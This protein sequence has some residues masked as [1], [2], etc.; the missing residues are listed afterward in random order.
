MV[1]DSFMKTNNPSAP[2]VSADLIDELEKQSASL[3]LRARMDKTVDDAALQKVLTLIPSIQAQFGE[4][5]LVP[6]KAVGHALFAFTGLLSEAMHARN[7]TSRD[8]L[9]AAAWQ[10]EEQLVRVFG[11]SYD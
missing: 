3:V 6:F 2:F 4:S 5:N 8:L 10:V 1:S 11:P 9:V 7:E